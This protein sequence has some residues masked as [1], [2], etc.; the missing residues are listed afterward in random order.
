[1]SGSKKLW[2][3]YAMEYYTAERKKELLPVT[4]VWM[5]LEGILLS[6]ISQAGKINTI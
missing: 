6:E 2:H 4:T 3:I 5:E 1:M